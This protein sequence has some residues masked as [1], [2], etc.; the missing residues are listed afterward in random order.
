MPDLRPDDRWIA[1]GG[2]SLKALRLRFAIQ[3]RWGREV[4][5]AAVLD[6]DLAALAEAIATAPATT[7]SP[8]PVPPAPAGARTAPATSEQQRLW[9]LQQRSPTSTA[10]HVGLAFEVHGPVDVGA[11]RR[12]LRR[13]VARHPAL[14]TAFRATPQGLRQEVAEPYDPWREP[15]GDGD[16]AGW[17]QHARTLFA[18]PFDLGQPHLLRAYWLTRDDGGVLLLHL[19]HIAVDGWSLDVLFRDLSAAYAATLDGTTGDPDG[20]AATPLDYARWQA[21]WFTHPTYR[22]HRDALRDHYAAVDETAAPLRPRR[23]RGDSGDHLLRTTIDAAGR[24]ALDRLGDE[25]GL[26][27]FPLLLTLFGWAVH[28][29]TGRTHPRVASP[30]ANRPVRDFDASVGMFANTVLLPLALAPQEELR[31]QLRRQAQAVRAVLDAQDVA[32]AHAVADHDFGTDTPLFDFLFV[33]D[34]TDFSTL[35]LRGCASRPV[36]LAPTD[37]KCPL[38]LSVVAHEGGFD[39]LWEYADDHFDEA[40]VVAAADLFRR[41]LD[42][43]TGTAPTT[44]AELVRPHRRALPDPGRGPRTPLGLPTVAESFARRVRAQPAAT[45]L[46]AGDRRLSYADLDGYAA[47][48]AAELTRQHPVPADGRHHVAL[49][50]EPSVE[51]VVALLAAARL[52]L[53]AVPLDRAYPPTLLRQV[54]RQ[55]RPLCVLLAPGDGPALDAIDDVGHPRHP[56]LLSTATEPVAPSYAGRPLYT[57]FTSGSTGTPKGVQVSDA[58]LVNLLRWQGGAG[59]LADAAAT[60]QFS[61]LS[62]DVSFQEIFGTLCG[63][64]TLHLPRPGWRQDMPALLEHLD[65]AGIARIFLPYVALQ[66]LA[67]HGVRLGRYPSPAAGRGHRR[68]TTDLHRQHPPLVRR[69]A[70]CAPVQPLR[71]HRDPCGQRPVPRRRPGDLADPPGHRPP[72]HQHLAA[73]GGPGRRGGAAGLPRAAADRWGPGRPV[74]PGRPG[75]GPGPLRRTARPR[76]VLPQRRPGPLRPR[77]TAALPGPRRPAGEG[78]RAPAGA[79]P[80][81]GG[82]AHPPGGGQRRGRPRPVTAGGLPAVPRRPADRRGADRPSR[83]AAA[84]LRAGGPVPVAGGVAAYRQREAGPPPGVDRAGPGVAAGTR[85]AG[86]RRVGS[87]GAAGRALRGRRRGADRTRAALLRRRGGQPGPDAFP[88]ARRRRGAAADHPRPVRARHHPPPRP[89][90]HRAAR[91]HRADPTGGRPGAGHHRAGRL[92]RGPTRRAGRRGR[93]GRPVARRRRPR[94]LLGDGGG[95]RPGHHALRRRRGPRRCPQPT[96]RAARFRPRT[97]RHQPPRGAADGPPATAPADELRRGVGAR[98]HRRSR[99]AAGRAARQLRREHL[100]PDDAARGRPGAAAGSLPTGAAP[101]EGLPR[102]QGRLPPAPDRAG[103]HRAGGLRQLTGRRP[104]RRRAAAAGRQ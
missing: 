96:R 58:L 34:N 9:L 44:L 22:A 29:V 71:P 63:G 79:G 91:R 57:L 92:R 68:R 4:P 25:L 85:R 99:A 17:R 86:G 80:G 5:P 51:H 12:A 6:G 78:Q 11:L 7:G 59:G 52:N 83:G 47:G 20:A 60:L 14:R 104:P 3:R 49:F 101:R 102:H 69:A 89:V 100:L 26:T 31:A 28:G 61:M 72:G 39:C 53:T 67:E 42:A 36:W 33:L 93:H 32:L 55:V 35:A 87:G 24:S 88:P 10:Y 30:V 45:A 40:D 65:T 19:H 74:L 76:V 48:L 54:L 90:P 66:L 23:Q 73:G 81:R 1:S 43:V 97:L 37:A 82:T 15:D 95:R 13:V 94:R 64:G 103:L 70:R 41:G 75:A 38:T 77:R 2:D 46:V 62:F 8:Y 84:R 21:D 56:V 18:V 27:R 16:P 50:F 98:R